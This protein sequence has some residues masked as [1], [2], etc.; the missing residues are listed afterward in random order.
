MKIIYCIIINIFLIHFTI[1][2]VAVIANKTLS[3]DK[4][5]KTELLDCYTGDIKKLDDGQTI[6]V[7]DLKHKIV[8]RETF[9]PFIDI[10]QQN[11]YCMPTGVNYEKNNTYPF[12]AYYINTIFFIRK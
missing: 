9:S 10:Y 7:F 11:L 4:I 12:F 5:S 8:S 3:K 1:A 2:Q 6:Y